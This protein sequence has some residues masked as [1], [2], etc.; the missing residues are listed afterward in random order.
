MEYIKIFFGFADDPREAAGW[1]TPRHLIF[2]TAVVLLT[3][4]AAILCAR[5]AKRRGPAWFRRVLKI[6]AAAMLGMETVKIVILCFRNHDPLAF[7]SALPLF[8]CSILLFTMP[9]AAFGRGRAAQ[10]AADFSFIFG[11]LC[12]IAGTYLAGNIFSGSPLLSFSLLVSVTEHALSGFFGLF[13]LL[14]GGV[15]IARKRYADYAL[16]LLGFE[17][18][19][20]LADLMNSRPNPLTG[21]EYQ[22]N[23][24]FFLSEDGTPFSIVAAIAGG[25]GPLYTILVALLYFVYLFAV[26][27]VYRLIVRPEKHGATKK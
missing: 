17:V 24:M 26:L 11:P 16:I 18:L 3:V 21:N 15:R 1:M 5:T 6:S 25:N 22:N 14:C 10:S 4:L 9:V 27:G 12:M 23:Y 19:A 13:L 2:A 7:L 8:L 20:Y